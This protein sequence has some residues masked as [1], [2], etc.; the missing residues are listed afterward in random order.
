MKTT[1]NPP[2][3]RS[4]PPGHHARRRAELLAVTAAERPRSS[5][6]I[7]LLA[8]AS[9]IAITAGVVVAVPALRDSGQ[10]QP[11]ASNSQA[12]SASTVRQIK[13]APA[14][15]DLTPAEMTAFRQ[16][17]ER[18][19]FT[20]PEWYD[21]YTTVAGIR[22]VNERRPVPASWLILRK[23]AQHTICIKNGRGEVFGT[24]GFGPESVKDVEYLFA[25]VD[26]KGQGT[27]PFT[28]PVTRV[29][30][31]SKDDPEQE[32]VLRHGFWFAAYDDQRYYTWNGT[33]GPKED[34]KL[35]GVPYG[36]TFR[37]YDRNGRLVY[38]SGKNGP[39]VKDCYTDPDG[40]RVLVVNSVKNPTPDKCRRTL[41]W[42]R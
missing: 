42:K 22:F 6:S 25:P 9:V 5:R 35:I 10:P 16:D 38:D 17:C 26:V 21:G 32:A 36:Y 20:Q 12:A 30:V 3:E 7:P 11:S 19:E 24:T 41:Y 34:S 31:Q 37:G 4:M 33:T 13:P 1:L 29:T 28:K 2:P 18:S 40:R 15:H 8:A 39:A 23:G 14:V 27:G